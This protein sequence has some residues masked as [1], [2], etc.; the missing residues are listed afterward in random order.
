MKF[1]G[2]YRVSTVKQG[3]SG[4]GLEAQKE[5]VRG[6]LNSVPRWKMVDEVVEVE[7]GKRNDRPELARA[8][9]LCRVH[10]AT[11]IVAK[12]DRLARNAHFVTGLME[13]GVDF[14]VVDCPHFNKLT[15]TILAAVA[16]AE[17]KAISERTKVALQ[18]AKARGV[19]LG[20]NRGRLSASVSLAGAK[21]SAQMR[22]GRAR[23]W[24]SDVLPVIRSIQADG[25]RSLRAVAA[26]LNE[27][28]VP[29]PSSGV[30]HGNSVRRVLAQ[31][32]SM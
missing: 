27:K 26:E 23:V 14:V 24:A 4:L 8:L 9:A 30:W 22:Q 3:V 12:L 20:G 28:G 31:T 13:S 10:R 17:A 6:Y 32:P 11:L 1:I 18:A 2:Y 25:A 5:T 21:A 19:R 7:S 29:S 16:E 15:I